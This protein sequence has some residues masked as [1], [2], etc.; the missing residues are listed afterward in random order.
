MASCSVAKSAH[1]KV[2][3][4][5][6]AAPAV[7]CQANRAFVPPTSPTR[8]GKVEESMSARRCLRESNCDR[9]RA[10]AMPVRQRQPS[11]TDHLADGQCSSTTGI[12]DA[13]VRQE[14]PEF[15]RH[16]VL[17]S[18][19]SSGKPG[20]HACS[21]TTRVALDSTPGKSNVGQLPPPTAVVLAESSAIP[22]CPA[23]IQA[24]SFPG[25]ASWWR[26]RPRRR[27]FFA[28]RPSSPNP[29]VPK[30]IERLERRRFYCQ[31]NL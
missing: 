5:D 11:H 21:L 1:G 7:A 4:S 23:A 16:I 13:H 8:R 27:P 28:H 26:R 29:G 15:T 9:R 30:G 19:K 2:A 17:H 25:R 20:Y 12:D 3:T 22:D 31:Q 10:I 24:A 6:S 18:R 14:N